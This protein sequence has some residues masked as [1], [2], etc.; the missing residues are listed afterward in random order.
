MKYG[1]NLFPVYHMIVDFSKLY[2]IFHSLNK[3]AIKTFEISIIRI[4]MDIEIK[5]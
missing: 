1:T 3:L 4:C 2:R 5:I